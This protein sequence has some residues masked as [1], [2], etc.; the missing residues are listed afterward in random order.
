MNLS[1]E[2]A[3]PI[4]VTYETVDGT[5]TAGEDYTAVSG[6]TVAFNR[7]N[8]GR[9][10]TQNISTIAITDDAIGEFDGTFTLRLTG[11]DGYTP[12]RSREQVVTI[13]DNDA[14]PL[15]FAP[16]ASINDQVWTSGTQI[17]ALVLPQASGGASAIRYSLNPTL[18]NGLTFTAG[19]RTLS[20]TLT[21]AATQTTYTLVASSGSETDTLSF[22]ITVRAGAP[23][24]FPTLTL[25]ASTVTYTNTPAADDS[26]DTFQFT[27]TPADPDSDSLGDGDVYVLAVDSAAGFSTAAEHIGTYGTLSS[28][29]IPFEQS[30]V[31]RGLSKACTYT[32]N[33]EATQTLAAGET[34]TDEFIIYLRIRT[35]SGQLFE[36]ASATFTVNLV[37][38]DEAEP[39]AFAP[40][41]S[42]PDQ[43]WTVG[44]AITSVVLP[45]AS[46]GIAAITYAVSPTL[47]TGLTFTRATRTIAGM[48]TAAQSARTYTLTASSGS[49]SVALTFDITVEP[50][51]VVEPVQKKPGVLIEPR[52]QAA[53]S[54]LRRHIDQFTEVTSMVIRDRLANRQTM[55]ASGSNESDKGQV[56]MS[57]Q[58]G[59]SQYSGWIAGSYAEFDGA[60]EGNQGEI[61]VGLDSVNDSRNIVFGIVVSVENPAL[62]VD[63][64]DYDATIYE[65]GVYGAW[66]PV[67]TLIFDAAAAYGFGSPEIRLNDVTAEYDAER[68]TA[69]GTVTGNFGLHVGK[70]QIAP[71]LG[72]IYAR[73]KLGAFEDSDNSIAPEETLSI[74]RA[75]LGPR[76]T[77]QQ[78]PLD[79]VTSARFQWDFDPLDDA[80]DGTVSG[81]AG[82]GIRYN[83]TDDLEMSLSGK[84]DGIGISDDF[85]TYSGR[86]EF[87]SRF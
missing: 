6:G 72:V 24:G 14:P 86:I 22:D 79:I 38:A 43:S 42:I 78:G 63:E 73:E 40:G 80:V 45:Q 64:A 31:D 51:D 21:A 35:S 71:Q 11:D 62:A 32:P 16:G 4:M 84:V 66:N 23:L 77:W 58:I 47:P 39:L 33:A 53:A 15:A 28:N 57:S 5:A 68:F 44:Q 41:A 2:P 69:R 48:P 65:F 50:S 52:R 70:A 75:T 36:E 18:P 81:V 3:G 82:L 1:G 10:P 55:Q 74:G 60:V 85:Q 49:E 30:F 61:Y 46:G 26:F 19:T 34:G 25:S 9:I 67:D 56:A 13:R 20:G 54:A 27:A 87:I 29:G 59:N 17:T 7:T 37:G 12:G 76:I 8:S 83:M